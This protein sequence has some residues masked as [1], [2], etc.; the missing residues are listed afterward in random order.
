MIKFNE[1]NIQEIHME[2]K[3]K[4]LINE[5]ERARFYRKVLIVVSISQIFGG[6]GLAAG[7][8]VGA[9]I[10]QEILGTEV[11]AGVP[12][13]LLTLG[14]A[15]AALMIGM[16]SQK[17]GRR[18]GLGIGFMLGGLGAVLV[19]TAAALNNVWLLFASLL[20]YGSG[21]AS[22]LQ[23]RYA[24]TDLAKPSQRGK[25]VSFTMVMTTFGAV[26]G[27]NL[28][29]FMGR[30]AVSWSLPALS[31]PFILG[32]AA[33]ILAGLVLFIMLRPDPLFIARQIRQQEA[34]TL[35]NDKVTASSAA[36]NRHK[37]IF[38][39][40]VM[41]LT[42]MVMVALMTM[43]PVHMGHHGHS[44]SAIGMVISIHVA[45]MY[46]PSLVTG[47]LVDRIGTTKMSVI[48]AVTL[49]MAGLFSAFA[50]GDSMILMAVGLAL[51]GLGWNFG[52]IS[53]TTAIVHG[54]T[55]ETRAKTQG[56]IDVFIALSGATGG[57]L[58]G[59]MMAGT[60]YMLLSLTGGLLSLCII[61][62][63]TFN[64]RA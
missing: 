34:D 39:A 25:A 57:A 24:G 62:L 45:A 43:T 47:M 58:S 1:I 59:M 7:V 22:N 55:P 13:A 5:T 52:L 14:S 37:I 23:A 61:P 60:S 42:Q 44:L 38:G 28:A 19:I 30:I 32:A 2:S 51:L 20:I 41:I 63:L 54:T 11:Y 33:Y 46:F 6:A 9:L 12:A 48:A 49:L 16:L 18:Y 10:A 21:T 31:G 8:T 26:L 40:F 53:G 27:P 50:P 4:L 64:R 3:E 56:K 17:F 15:G 29:E 36:T 35:N